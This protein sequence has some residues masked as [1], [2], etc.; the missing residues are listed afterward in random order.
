M[1]TNLNA[2]SLLSQENNLKEWFLYRFVVILVKY[3]CI[4]RNFT[5]SVH[6]HLNEPFNIVCT[7]H[8]YSAL[9]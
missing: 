6:F 1:K 7:V 4:Y 3:A 9:K 5:N 2:I 8:N